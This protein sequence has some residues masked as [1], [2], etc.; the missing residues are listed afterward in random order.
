MS[1]WTF[2]GLPSFQTKGGEYFDVLN[3]WLDLNAKL[4]FLFHFNPNQP[5]TQV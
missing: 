3:K 2:G 5:I 4:I 1:T